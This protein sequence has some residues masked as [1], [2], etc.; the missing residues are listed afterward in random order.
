MIDNTVPDY[1]IN[2]TKKDDLTNL[3]ERFNNFTVKVEKDIQEYS[4]CADE[5]RDQVYDKFISNVRN[6][7]DLKF[8]N[9]DSKIETLGQDLYSQ[10]GNQE[11]IFKDTMVLQSET[12]SKQTYEIQELRSLI[13]NLNTKIVEVQNL[14]NLVDTKHDTGSKYSARVK[15]QEDNNVELSNPIDDSL[16]KFK[17]SPEKQDEFGNLQQE[18]EQIE[19]SKKEIEDNS[20]FGFTPTPQ[21][22]IKGMSRTQKFS[23]EEKEQEQEKLEKST[24]AVKI[25]Q[26]KKVEKDQIKN[27]GVHF[28]QDLGHKDSL[29]SL[30]SLQEDEKL[31]L[32]QKSLVINGTP[33][34]EEDGEQE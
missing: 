21:P 9:L 22:A 25:E 31:Q 23:L 2:Y 27:P 4:T 13:S 26:V 14:S 30:P 33:Q 34:V 6:E 16:Q 12:I 18:V 32:S 24:V 3:R 17:M 29:P 7:W 19:N 11:Q 28:M 5:I 8:E 15:G 10:L 20:V 1:L